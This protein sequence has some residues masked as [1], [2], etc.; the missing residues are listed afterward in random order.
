VNLGG[1]A[2]NVTADIAH[3]HEI[4][5]CETLVRR[6]DEKINVAVFG[7]LTASDRPVKEKLCNTE[8]PEMVAVLSKTAEGIV[9]VHQVIIAKFHGLLRT[10]R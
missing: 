5:D 1:G 2:E 4:E 10:L 6:L 9:T 3:A 8:T 7:G